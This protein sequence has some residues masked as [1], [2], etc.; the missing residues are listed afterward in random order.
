MTTAYI[1]MKIYQF[2]KYVYLEREFAKEKSRMEHMV[3]K[4]IDELFQYQ[5]NS[6]IPNETISDVM[7][8]L[9]NLSES[10]EDITIYGTLK[11]KIE[12]ISL[13]TQKIKLSSDIL[14]V[15]YSNLQSEEDIKQ[16]LDATASLISLLNSADRADQYDALKYLR[17]FEINFSDTTLAK[18]V[19]RYRLSKPKELGTVTEEY[20]LQVYGKI[21]NNPPVY[22]PKTGYFINKNRWKLSRGKSKVV[23]KNGFLSKFEVDVLYTD[24][25]N[26]DSL[27][28]S[29]KGSY[30]L[31]CVL[32]QE[33]DKIT[34]SFVLNFNSNNTSLYLY[35]I[36][37]G[38]LYYNKNSFWTNYF[39]YYFDKQ[40]KKQDSLYSLI[41][42]KSSKDGIVKRE[43]ISWIS[44]SALNTYEKNGYLISLL[45]G[46]SYK[47][48]K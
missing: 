37:T 11:D 2:A 7:L 5:T 16:E 43:K 32:A 41:K 20:L 39:S 23:A 36:S 38:R 35:D 6:N 27:P 48:L 15:I 3:D 45:G 29:K 26:I 19:R 12:E 1:L 30:A 14:A 44:N 40:K 9:N 25:V 22:N 34:K 13:V 10:L 17:K 28:K 4:I 47:L 21:K 33:V 8:S 42:K 31:H 24:N 18:D 46:K